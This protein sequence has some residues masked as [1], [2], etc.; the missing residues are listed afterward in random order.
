MPATTTRLIE[1][2]VRDHDIL[3]S[4]IFPPEQDLWSPFIPVHASFTA[5]WAIATHWWTSVSKP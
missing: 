3:C 5:V 1:Q 4:Q 2:A